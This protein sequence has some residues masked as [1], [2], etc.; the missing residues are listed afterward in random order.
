M[1][2]V[3][4]SNYYNYKYEINTLNL[5]FCCPLGATIINGACGCDSTGSTKVYIGANVIPEATLNTQ[6]LTSKNALG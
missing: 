4:D 3:C 5:T 1:T 2:C 6:A